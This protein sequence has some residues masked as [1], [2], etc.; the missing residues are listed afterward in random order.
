MY[1]DTDFTQ[2]IMI[3][4]TLVGNY[5]SKQVNKHGNEFD[6]YKNLYTRKF[7]R[8]AASMFVWE[9]LPN[10]LQSTWLEKLIIRN[11][12]VAFFEDPRLGYV[13]TYGTPGGEYNIYGMP[14]D[15][16]AIAFNYNKRIKVDMSDTEMDKKYGVIIG[17]DIQYSSSLFEIQ[18]YASALA[19]IKQLIDV[20]LTTTATPWLLKATPKTKNT[21]MTA[22]RKA[23]T[24]DPFIVADKN[25]DENTLDVLNLNAPYNVDKLRD[26]YNRIEN[27]CMTALGISNADD[28]KKERQ[29]VDEVNA[30]NGQINLNAKSRLDA[31]QSAVDTINKR[32]GLDIKVRLADNVQYDKTPKNIDTPEVQEG[33]ASD[34]QVHD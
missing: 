1:N 5:N 3:G 7:L 16:N 10:G 25:L 30:N 26:E 4:G 29:T 15:Y 8:M 9:N 18:T 28:T 32:F 19:N 24:G 6:K 20:N 33:D 14:I 22:Y 13:F 34:G 21:L 23:V 17:N 2:P 27:E 11:G 31:R 12:S